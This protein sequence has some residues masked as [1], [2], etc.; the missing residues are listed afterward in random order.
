MSLW[1][2][3]PRSSI[4]RSWL[5]IGNRTRDLPACSVVPQPTTLPRA[6]GCKMLSVILAPDIRVYYLQVENIWTIIIRVLL[7]IITVII[8]IIII[9]ITTTIIII[10]IAVLRRVFTFMHPPK[11]IKNEI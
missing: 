7:C 2:R 3:Y 9:L 11:F 10:I 4:R 1:R 6:P 5:F 8:I